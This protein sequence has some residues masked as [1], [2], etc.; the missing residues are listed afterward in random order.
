MVAWLVLLLAIT[1]VAAA[2]GF[3]GILAGAA[4]VAKI[5]FW[6][7]LSLFVVS[8]LISLVASLMGRTGTTAP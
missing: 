8:F 3:G 4:A 2:V 6:I 7:F 5:L 1:V